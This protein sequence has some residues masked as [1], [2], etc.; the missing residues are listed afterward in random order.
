MRADNPID[1]FGCRSATGRSSRTSGAQW[2][3]I[4]GQRDL[5]PYIP[6]ISDTIYRE[7]VPVQKLVSG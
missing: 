2:H 7:L 6:H 3:D 5:V 4:V 1:L